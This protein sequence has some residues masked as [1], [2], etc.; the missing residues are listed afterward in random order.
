MPPVPKMATVSLLDDDDDDDDADG[1]HHDDDLR[2]ISRTGASH[3]WQR[4][5]GASSVSAAPVPGAGPPAVAAR[6]SWRPA[7]VIR[8]GISRTGA[9]HPCACAS[10]SSASAACARSL[11]SSSRPP[12]MPPQ[13]SPLKC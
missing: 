10:A 12:L 3:P 13:S 8:G 2:G 5:P 9:S 6:E 11:A 1:D 7:W 4:R